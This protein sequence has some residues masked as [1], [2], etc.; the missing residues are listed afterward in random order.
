MLHVQVDVDV[1]EMYRSGE[2]WLVLVRPPG[3]GSSSVGTSRRGSRIRRPT[4]ADTYHRNPLGA[5]AYTFDSQFRDER[6]N[7][8]PELLP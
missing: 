2:H 5:G 1:S 3:V 7:I 4:V 8:V 6:G